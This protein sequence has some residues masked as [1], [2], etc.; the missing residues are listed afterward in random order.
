MGERC[1][2]VLLLMVS[3]RVGSCGFL[4]IIIQKCVVCFLGAA[5]TLASLARSMVFIQSLKA[6]DIERHCRA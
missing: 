1:D 4:G 3:R 6:F 2:K 5:I